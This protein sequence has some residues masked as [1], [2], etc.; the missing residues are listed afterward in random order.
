MGLKSRV[1]C[2]PRRGFYSKGT[3][4]PNLSM[5][6]LALELAPPP[7]SLANFVAGRNAAALGAVRELVG[8]SPTDRFVYLWGT[9]GSGR[10]HLLRAAVAAALETGLASRYVEGAALDAGALPETDFAAIDDVDRLDAAQQIALFDLYN[11]VRA[12]RGRL[13]VAGDRAPRDLAL[14]EDLRTRLGACVA[15]E[16]HPLSDEE[17]AA[18]LRGEAAHRGL[19]LDDGAVTYLLSHVAR[20]MTTLMAVLDALDRASLERQRALT[21]PFVRETVTAITAKAEKTQ[22]DAKE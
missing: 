3:H 2:V 5:Q 20:D 8:G 16:V 13:L 17:K 9:H 7:P 21:M 1:P 22:R 19:R 15:F 14:R 10:T 11:R 18:A 12:D 6:Q 4:R